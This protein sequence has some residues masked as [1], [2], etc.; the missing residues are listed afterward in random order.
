MSSGVEIRMPFMDWRLVTYTFITIDIKNWKWLQ[1][2]DA[3]KGIVPDSIR[4]RRDKIGWNAPVMSGYLDLEIEIEQ[5]LSFSSSKVP[6]G[7]EK[8]T[9]LIILTILMVKM[10]GKRIFKFVE[11]LVKVNIY[12]IRN[13]NSYL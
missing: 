6:C 7:F 1:V 3:M 8:F 12:V 5:S 2:R 13:Y 11:E 4:L 9:N 10:F